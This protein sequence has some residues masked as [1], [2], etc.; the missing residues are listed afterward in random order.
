MNKTAIKA[1]VRSSDLLEL[2][3]SK[4]F[5]IS[6]FK[7]FRLYE[8][9]SFVKD[10]EAVNHSESNSSDLI[11][12]PLK[13]LPF[14]PGHKYELAT[15]DNFFIPIDF[16]Y[17]S[18]TKEFE[19]KYR[20][21]GELGALY[22]LERTTF[23]IF[24][25]FAIRMVLS[26]TKP[27]QREETYVLSHDLDTGV[28]SITLEGDY[29]GAKYTYFV[30]IFGKTFEIV[31]PYAYSVDTNSRH[32]FVINPNKIRAISSAESGLAP[33]C[34]PTQA[35]IYECSVRDMTSLSGL[36]DKGTYAAL[37]KTG[38]KD[39]QGMPMGLDYL[40]S[41]GVSHIQLMPTLD[42]Q[43]ID[44]THPETSYN[45][46]YD[47]L[48]FM[49]N[50]GSYSLHPEDPYCRVMELRQLVSAFHE[51]GLRVISDVVYNHVYSV[52]FNVLNIL[53]PGYYFRINPDK[54]LS[55]GSGC[56]NDFESRNYMA[57]KLILDSLCHS[58]D[59]YGFDGFRFDLMGILDVET[60]TQ[61]QALL[62][63]K[64]PDILL[65]GE[66][67]DLWTNLPSDQKGSVINSGKL[68][69]FAFFN[70]RFRDV[71]KGKT[72]ES[73]LAVKGYLSGDTNYIDGFKHVML[74]SSSPL[75]FAPMFGSPRQ[76]INYVECHDNHALYDKLKACCPEEKEDMIFRRIK[77]I[78]VSIL[79]A[80]GIPFFHAGQE[81]GQ[82]K[83]KQGNT[84]NAGDKLNGFRYDLL[85]QRRELYSFFLEAIRMKERF[86][87]FCNGEY[88]TLREHMSFENLENNA[89]KIT[90]TLKDCTFYLIFNPTKKTFLYA[91]DD[92]VKLIFNEMGDVSAKD[93]YVRLAIVNATSALLFF[94]EKK[95]DGGKP[96]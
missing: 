15:K 56:G 14:V 70:D 75:A 28:F 48:L 82:S 4:D 2:N 6:S 58:V 79:F 37:T 16:S 20:F 22:T 32:G 80:C 21:D 34:D 68:S 19:E 3:V 9:D 78:T 84:Y 66:G 61:A 62:R 27:G 10:L 46:G 85:D 35:V 31:D 65:Y 54:S 42:F 95:A 1:I 40:K 5:Y 52:P 30:T 13:N 69:D 45:W 12:L 77:M 87:T 74:G 26:I 25:P 63:Q 94:K 60:L 73:E 44:D 96:Q 41:L 76:S 33:F 90:Y 64:K 92:D 57:R 55:N 72:S 86:V 81:I 39:S 67:W 38:L 88:P 83:E 11:T 71:V 53:V 8:D 43:T 29:D 47:P 89:L 24:S 50:E 51:A 36:P 49:T 59:F 17:L 91:F 18:K 23:R 93:F 7:S